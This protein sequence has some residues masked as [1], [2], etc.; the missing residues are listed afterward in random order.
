MN[1]VINLTKENI[2]VKKLSRL[3]KFEMFFFIFAVVLVIFSSVYMHDSAFAITSA[4]CGIIYT[5]LAGKGKVYCYPFGIIGTVCCAYLCYKIALYGN[6]M[7][8]IGYYFPMEVFGFFTWRKHLNKNTDEI[9]KEKLTD[10][11]RLL[12]TFLIILS[13]ALMFFFLLKINDKA[14]LADAAM[15]V[16]SIAG[17]ILTVKRA[18]EQWIVWT[19]SNILSIIMWFNAYITG[20][21]IFS[22]F[23]VR[24]VYFALGIYFFIKWKRETTQELEDLDTINN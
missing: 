20:E 17:M 16:F 15:T 3:S 6:F 10:K 5:I 21:K 11:E 8:H 1:N 23:V 13:T 24:I 7:L 14:P 4:A 22:I 19:C 12:T 18:I 2:L 9:I